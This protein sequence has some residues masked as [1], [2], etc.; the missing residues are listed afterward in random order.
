MST[1]DVRR[2]RDKLSAKAAATDK[3]EAEDDR[4]TPT[5]RRLP[6]CKSTGRPTG[7][8]DA[9]TARSASPD[10][11]RQTKGTRP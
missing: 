4:S 7:R 6:G 11:A 1:G 3:P 10:A 2:L 8:Q 9:S 5:S